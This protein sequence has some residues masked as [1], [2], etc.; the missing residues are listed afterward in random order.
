MDPEA[1]P[2]RKR[3]PKDNKDDP[4]HHRSRNRDLLLQDVGLA[5]SPHAL[6]HPSD[7]DAEPMHAPLGWRLPRRTDAERVRALAGSAPRRMGRMGTAGRTYRLRGV[8]P[9]PACPDRGRALWRSDATI[10]RIAPG[11]REVIIGQSVSG[12]FGYGEEMLYRHIFRTTKA[13][14]RFLAWLDRDGSLSRMHE[15]V[16][17][18]FQRG[19][20]ALGEALDEIADRSGTS[21]SSGEQPRQSRSLLAG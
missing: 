5:R 1:A 13:R 20:T 7:G 11:S 6:R 4:A 14:K 9:L 15:L 17:L 12:P 21:K 10:V 16:A 3:Q 19:T 8:R 2:A 18:A